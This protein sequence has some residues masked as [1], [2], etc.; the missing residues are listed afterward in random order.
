MN[1]ATR[2]S[3]PV[4]GLVS[5]TYAAWVRVLAEL[6]RM[7]PFVG[8]TAAS[9]SLRRV[10][11][12]AGE[13][14]HRIEDHI[15]A[16]RIQPWSP[17][18]LAP[19]APLPPLSA[20]ASKIGVFPVSASPFEWAHLVGGLAAMAELGLDHVVYIVTEGAGQGSSLLPRE[21]RHA[22]TRE[23]LARFPPLLLYS[24]VGFQQDYAGAMSVFRLLA[25]NASQ[26]MEV[27]LITGGTGGA[28]GEEPSENLVGQIRSAITGRLH[29]YDV[30][31]HPVSFVVSRDAG[32]AARAVPSP[33]RV[34]VD[35][36]MPSALPGAIP[37]ALSG[38][39]GRDALAAL[40]YTAFRHVRRLWMHT[41]AS[42]S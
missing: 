7:V 1:G 32:P 42:R 15:L 28:I 31:M 29:G 9:E 38:E 26:P 40:P 5:I 11:A 3:T 10:R 37:A 2:P 21:V 34:S 39:T 22:M 8:D 19:D 33:A 35:F 18:R 12:A 41:E 20:C 27:C 17:I 23:L 4:S 14:L 13:Y 36:P 6:A 30:S 16:G 25:L 24:P